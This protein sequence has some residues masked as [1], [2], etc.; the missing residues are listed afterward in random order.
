M[1]LIEWRDALKTGIAAVDHEHHALVELINRLY[2]RAAAGGD[3]AAVGE[4]LAELNDAIAAHFALEERLMR[5]YRYRRYREHK[6][7]HERLL[8]QIR[9]IMEEHEHGT[10]ADAAAFLGDRLDVWFSRHFH[11]HDTRLHEAGIAP[12]H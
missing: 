7:D 10:F 6:E 4:F 12:H 5:E 3:A 2:E 9:D 8:D 11:T 1:Q